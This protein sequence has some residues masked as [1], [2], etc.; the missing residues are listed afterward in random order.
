MT[1]Q[2]ALCGG[3]KAILALFSQPQPQP[4]LACRSLPTGVPPAPWLSQVF[5]GQVFAVFPLTDIA[6]WWS[7]PDLGGNIPD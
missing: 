7:R 4:P 2:G 1:E 6:P 3:H 5:M